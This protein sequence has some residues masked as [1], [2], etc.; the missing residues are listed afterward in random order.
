MQAGVEEAEDYVPRRHAERNQFVGNLPVGAVL[1]QPHLAVVDAQVQYDA[2]DPAL[3]DPAEAEHKVLVALVVLW[4]LA[5][6]YWGVSHLLLPNPVKVWH[7]FTD[8]IVTGEF[9]PDLKVT[10]TE[11]VVAF[12]LSCTAGVTLGYLVSRSSY[13]IR[14]FEPLIALASRV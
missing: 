2:L 4:Y 7:E 3:T 6:T 8:I 9:W 11:L 12:V 5:T 10:L 1:L 14:V 13:L